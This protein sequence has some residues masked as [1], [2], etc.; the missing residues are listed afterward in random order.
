[1]G[2]LEI[3]VGV[4]TIA[5]LEYYDSDDLAHALIEWRKFLGEANVKTDYESVEDASRNVTQYNSPGIRAILTPS[6]AEEVS[7]IVDIAIKYK[8]ALY[9]V[10]T[11]FNWGLG[12]RLPTAANCVLVELY[13]LNKIHEVN[14]HFHY[15]IIEP[16]VTQYQLSQYIKE[17]NLDLMIN[18]TGSSPNSSIIGNIF[19]R[20]SGFHKHRAEDLRALEIKLGNGQHL[21]TGFWH[22]AKT[23]RTIHHYRQGLG[24]DMTG[25]FSQ[26]N[27]GIITAAVVNLYPKPESMKMFW[28]TV[29]EDHFPDFI[30]TVSGLYKKHYLNSVMHIGNEKRMNIESGGNVPVWTGMCAI[31]GSDAY[32]DFISGEM[33]KALKDYC[34]SIDFLTK[35]D[36]EQADPF[37]CMKENY[38]LHA[39]IPSETFIKYMYKSANDAAPPAN[40]NLDHGRSGMLCCL[41]VLPMQGNDVRDAIKILEEVGQEF[42]ITPAAT[43]NPLNDIALEAVINIYWDRTNPAE[44]K[45]AHACNNKLHKVFY[46]RGFRF[47]RAD[48]EN[49]KHFLH[50]DDP[51]WDTAKELK[52]SLDPHHIIAPKRYNII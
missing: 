12:S 4:N 21:R 46:R 40:Y 50:E 34:L 2:K 36:V 17:N 44:T 52:K 27:Y 13:K 11:G 24:P 25:L 39:G 41:P 19:E 16:G 18:A 49:I 28:C 42:N 6:N 48:I 10:S 8:V 37:S 38:E 5:S 15:A 33:R 51:F 1:M 3:N 7:R 26:S 35:D 20:G 29:A 31:E 43:F 32:I 22:F 9:P 47:Y 14:E 45:N 30:D 23:D